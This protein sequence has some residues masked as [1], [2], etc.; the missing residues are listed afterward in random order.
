MNGILLLWN[1][2]APVVKVDILKDSKGKDVRIA[3]LIGIHSWGIG[4]GDAE[5]PGVNGRVSHVLEWIEDYTG[6][7]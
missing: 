6:N 5:Y 1:F 3:T 2:L 4:C 7:F